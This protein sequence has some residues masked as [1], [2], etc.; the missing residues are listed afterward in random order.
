MASTHAL[1]APRA[2]A[3]SALDALGRRSVARAPRA[4]RATLVAPRALLGPMDAEKSANR[5][6][7]EGRGRGSANRTCARAP[8]FDR[9]TP[10]VPR[11]TPGDVPPPVRSVA[12]DPP[13]GPRPSPATAEFDPVP[14]DSPTV[15]WTAHMRWLF[16]RLDDALGPLEP[17]P[18][19]P[20]LASASKPGKARAETWVYASP[21]ARR[22]R[23]TYVDA[24]EES[25][26]LNVVAY[27]EP[28][29]AGD[30]PNHLGDAPLLGVDLLSLAKGRNVLLG[31]DLQPLS[32]EPAYL[33]RYVDRLAKIRDEFSDVGLAVPSERFYED[34]RFF[35]PAM[36]F[37]RPD[38]PAMATAAA[39]A[40]AAAAGA[41]F[42]P[43]D[44]C[45]A[46]AACGKALLERRSLD[47]VRAYCDAFLA[48]LG[49]D[50]GAERQGVAE[51]QGGAERQ[52]AEDGADLAAVAFA[53]NAVRGSGDSGAAPPM[54]PETIEAVVERAVAKAEAAV[55]EVKLETAVMEENQNIY[56]RAGS[57]E[58]AATK[59][60]PV[61]ATDAGELAES[62][63]RKEGAEARAE[64]VERLERASRARVLSPAETAAAQD[65]HDDWQRE[66]D[67]AVKMFA[68]LFGKAWADRLAD[69]VLFPSGAAT[70]AFEAEREERA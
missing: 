18:I 63:A 30:F 8:G 14:V 35:S 15:P 44:V 67:P 6:R 29:P 47:A 26:I 24:G 3:E 62:N 25:Q 22:V 12:P 23:F 49:V 70:A 57:A 2:V 60:E 65:A 4:T 55:E 54:D 68:G 20:E 9:R 69:E 5:S 52:G 45:A 13:A 51:R 38:A 1:S 34:A 36:L 59:A 61:R 58:T 7:R 53:N 28:N 33:D 46:D 31:V 37:A 50:K 17:V 64:V 27:P 32:R 56:D 43:T 40:A 11:A 48:L 16:R 21:T 19:P 39:A 10:R 42:P 41:E 66:R